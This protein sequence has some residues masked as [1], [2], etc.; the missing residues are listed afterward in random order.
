M[1]LLTKQ[2][3]RISSLIAC[4][5]AEKEIAKK[6]FISYDTVHTH[7]RNIRKKLGAKNNVG[8]AVRWLLSL[9]NPKAFFPAALFLSLHLGTIF[10]TASEDFR[11]PNA[12]RIARVG[13]KLKANVL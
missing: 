12:R 9:D 5:F 7:T 1:E 6:L 3:T 4:E 8:I 2:E 10:Y 13:F 11:R